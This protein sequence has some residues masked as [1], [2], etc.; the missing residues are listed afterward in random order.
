MLSGEGLFVKA[1]NNNYYRREE[2][3]Q[4]REHLRW[5]VNRNYSD[6]WYEAQ[7]IHYGRDP[8][9]SKPTTL[10]CASFCRAVHSGNLEVPEYI[11]VIETG[12]REERAREKREGKRPTTT[13]DPTPETPPTAD[14]KK[15]KAYRIK[16]SIQSDGDDK[17]LFSISRE[18]KSTNPPAAKRTKTSD[19]PAD[20]D[21]ATMSES[22]SSNR[23]DDQDDNSGV[24]DDDKSEASSSTITNARYNNADPADVSE[25]CDSSPSSPM[26]PSPLDLLA[27]EYYVFSDRAPV[28]GYGNGGYDFSL[29]LSDGQLWGKFEFGRMQGVLRFDEPPPPDP[30]SDSVPFMWRGVWDAEGVDPVRWCGEDC[31]GWMKF[32]GDGEIEGEFDGLTIDFW[33]EKNATDAHEISARDMECE[34]ELVGQQ[35]LESIRGDSLY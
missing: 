10:E 14:T 13:T 3:E 6:A 11:S 25:R 29:A 26:S 2:A 23:E 31:R 28:E 19:T 17:V 9:S 4:L 27:G 7:L 5:G 24:D 18:G 1:S 20:L 16:V 21:T 22:S 33:G 35:W 12:L 30:S 32:L 34:W 8:A 15:R